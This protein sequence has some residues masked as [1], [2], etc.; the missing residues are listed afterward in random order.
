[1]TPAWRRRPLQRPVSSAVS[2]SRF[3]SGLEAV[4]ED[5]VRWLHCRDN[6][7]DLLGC[8]YKVFMEVTGAVTLDHR[9]APS[10]LLLGSL[11][12]PPCSGLTA[13]TTPW[14]RTASPG[15]CSRRPRR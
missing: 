3:I 10:M 15:S 12:P 2:C 1:M 6:T 5:A 7:G 14:T 8:L 13:C 11:L 4:V 9:S